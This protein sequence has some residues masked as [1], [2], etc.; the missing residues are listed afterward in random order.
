MERVILSGGMPISSETFASG[1]RAP[2][3]PCGDSATWGRPADVI[4]GPQGE[5]YISDDHGNRVYR[6]VNAN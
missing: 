1:W 3:L 5:M 2:G 4:F 6:V